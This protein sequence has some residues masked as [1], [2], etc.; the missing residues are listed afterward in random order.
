MVNALQGNLIT[1][2]IFENIQNWIINF[3]TEDTFISSAADL[4]NATMESVYAMLGANPTESSYF[5]AWDI[6]SGLYTTFAAIGSTLLVLFFLW[7][8]CR[9]VMDVRQ[10]IGLS[11]TIKIF[12]RLII[13][14]NVFTYAIDWM[15]A[16]FRWAISLLNITQSSAVTI[17]A[18]KLTQEITQTGWG[19]LTRYLFTWIF[20]AV[21]AVCSLIIIITCVGRF[22][23]LYTIIP[24]GTIAL[25]TLAGG[26]QMAQTG[27]AWIKTFLTYVFE[28]VVIGIVL[29]V[30]GAFISASSFFDAH[31]SS[32]L[33]VIMEAII[34]VVAVTAVVKG[35]EVTLR[36]ALNL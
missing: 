14:T 18:H 5:Q 24:L 31:T 12:I 17:N 9:D 30:S 19:F 20:F 33:L 27:Y 8:Y 28:I 11:S 25:S 22:I 15:P 34:K 6:V 4:W 23:K 10:D 35:S 2:S 16:F 13:A 7:G 1:A 36:K 29:A 3:F 26:G 32:S 21:V